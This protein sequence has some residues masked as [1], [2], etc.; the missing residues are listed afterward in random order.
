MQ[1]AFLALEPVITAYPDSYNFSRN[2]IYYDSQAHPG[3]HI[4]AYYKMSQVCET[5]NIKS[6]QCFPLRNSFVPGYFQIDTRILRRNILRE[7][8]VDYSLDG[9]LRSWEKVVDLQSKAFKAQ[10][11]DHQLKFR[12]SIQTDGVGVSVLKTTS[13]TRA[14]GPRR[15]TVRANINEPNITDL[16]LEDLRATE[17]RCV[18][19]DPNRRDLL[20]C[21]HEDSTPEQKQILRYTKNTQAKQRKQRKY[22]SIQQSVKDQD[23]NIALAE[24]RLSRFSRSSTSPVVF[25]RYIIQRSNVATVLHQHYSYTTT[26]R[27]GNTPRVPLHRKLRL[28][29][30]INRNREDDRLLSDLRRSFGDN[31]VLIMGNWSSGNNAFHEPIRGIG[32]RRALRKRG[33]TV[34][35]LDEFMTSRHCP[36]C[37]Q[38]SLKP[39]LRVRNPRP[40]RREENP[41]VLCHGLLRC[42]NQNCM[43]PSQTTRLWNRDVAAVCNFRH[44]L[45]ALRSD[46]HRPLRF[47]R[48]RHQQETTPR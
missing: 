28:S 10:G 8:D 30:I 1:D 9:K 16:S 47:L 20:F 40:W 14:G 15:Q 6:F 5:L 38:D 37:F 29:S 42:N 11:A 19:V 33:M 31:S 45:Q 25:A 43:Q 3:K 21:M 2:S 7:N 13:D 46:G 22:R 48:R 18:L 17:G 4:L 36:H 23:R 39:F 24:A 41:T 12:G 32:M 34:L 26:L 44:I 27:R 35:M